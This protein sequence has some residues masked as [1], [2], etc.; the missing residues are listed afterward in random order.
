MKRSEQ[1][2]QNIQRVIHVA[3][4]LFIADGIAATPISRIAE[5]AGLTPT[6]LYRYFRNKERACLC[7]VARCIGDVFL[8]FME[9][10]TREAASCKNGYEK[11]VVC[12]HTIFALMT[13]G[14]SGMTIRAKCSPPTRRRGRATTSTMSSGSITTARSPSRRSRRCVRAWPTGSIRPDVN[15]YAVYQCLLNAY[16]GTTIYEN[17]SFGVSPVVV[18]QFTGEMLVNY[19]KNE[20]STPALCN[21]TEKTQDV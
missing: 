4:S 2:E 11:F 7:R 16:T 14:R 10:Y 1:R 5:A 3:Q 17:L 8:G 18:V 6:S 9:Q 19:I 13:A 20:P 21:K 12:M 15:I